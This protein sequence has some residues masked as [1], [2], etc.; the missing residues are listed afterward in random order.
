MACF[1]VLD[2]RSFTSKSLYQGTRP[3]S[4]MALISETYMFLLFEF[5]AF[6]NAH[7]CIDKGDI[8]ANIDSVRWVL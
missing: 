8:P 5:I 2:D 3:G 4:N 7:I 1:V 6:R